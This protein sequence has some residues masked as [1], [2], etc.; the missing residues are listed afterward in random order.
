M[1][2]AKVWLGVLVLVICGAIFSGTAKAAS[3]NN[4]LIKSSIDSSATP[5]V[6]FLVSN[7]KK[8]D[9]YKNILNIILVNGI[10]I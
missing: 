2:E 8:L 9:K 7:E 1:R 6:A 3:E 4:L 5:K 10:I